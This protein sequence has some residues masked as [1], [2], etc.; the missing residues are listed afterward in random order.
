MSLRS[1]SYCPRSEPTP[2]AL[3][4][5]ASIAVLREAR[6][7]AHIE[8]RLMQCDH[9]LARAHGRAAA[10]FASADRLAL[11]SANVAAIDEVNELSIA[12]L[13]LRVEALWAWRRLLESG[14]VAMLIDQIELSLAYQTECLDRQVPRTVSVADVPKM[15]AQMDEANLALGAWDGPEE[16]IKL[17]EGADNVA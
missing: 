17:M 14:D 9:L 5:D 2:S 15:R 1:A 4:G 7:R 16:T 8:R 12:L 10:W 11:P 13:R 3:A 6:L